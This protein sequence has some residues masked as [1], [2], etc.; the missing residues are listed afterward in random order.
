ME[1]SDAQ[2]DDLSNV[3]DARCFLPRLVN[4]RNMLSQ[5]I[6]KRASN[7][8]LIRAYSSSGHQ[9]KTLG[10]IGAGQMGVGIA[11]VAA[12]VGKLQVCLVDSKAEPL[13]RGTKFMGAFI[14]KR[15]I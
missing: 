12:Q 15:V 9:V 14:V 3:K 8:S 13:K 10:V 7:A 11:L 5:L 1:V 4:T 6:R 2:I